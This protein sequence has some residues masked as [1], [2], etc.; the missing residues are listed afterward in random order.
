MRRREDA[1]SPW[2]YPPL[3][4]RASASLINR[5]PSCPGVV[6]NHDRTIPKKKKRRKKRERRKKVEICKNGKLSRAIRKD[7]VGGRFVRSTRE[8]R[9]NFPRKM[10]PSL[11]FAS[12][13]FLLSPPLCRAPPSSRTAVS[14]SGTEG[15]FDPAI[16]VFPE[17]EGT[18]VA[19]NGDRLT[20]LWLS[21][22]SHHC[23][24]TLNS[25]MREG[26]RGDGATKNRRFSH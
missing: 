11:F 10:F 22:S 19:G 6:P 20:E 3:A 17:I 23:H 12:P 21:L 14:I 7:E 2:H 9:S 18:V 13:L 4:L 15:K 5:P 26:G 16:I 24:A 8:N 1:L 25:R